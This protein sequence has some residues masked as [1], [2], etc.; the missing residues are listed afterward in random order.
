MGLRGQ[1]A[2][3]TGAGGGLGAVTAEAL[4]YAGA[5]VAVVCRTPDKVEAVAERILAAGE[6]GAGLVADV[7]DPAQVAA[8]LGAVEQRLGPVDLLV[9]NAAVVTPIGEPWQ[10]DPAEW[11]RAFEINLRGPYLCTRAVLPA[12]LARQRG[13]IVNIATGAVNRSSAQGSAYGA[14]KAALLH[15]GASLADG[16]APHGIRVFGVD[17]GLMPGTGMSDVVTRHRAEVRQRLERGDGIPPD[18]AARL[19]AWLA[20]GGPGDALA[21]RILSVHDDI[22]QLIARADEIQRGDLYTIRTRK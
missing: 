21:G 20:A 17:P 2:L 22:P 9:N 7:S 18:R 14:S 3:V 6:I 5:Q 11:W 19:I 15:W 10:E 8:M 16:L 12:M 4:A 13:C 1:V